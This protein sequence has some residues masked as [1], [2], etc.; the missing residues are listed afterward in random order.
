MKMM[1]DENT[2]SA[3]DRHRYCVIRRARATP[4]MFG[5]PGLLLRSVLA[6]RRI[7]ELIG[8]AGKSSAK[9]G[10]RKFI[11]MHRH[12][13]PCALHH[14]LHEKSADHES[15]VARRKNPQRE[16]KGFHRLRPR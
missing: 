11:Q 5:Q 4:E 16:S 8:E 1:R 13:P 3:T 2:A 10:G 12:D 6:A 7:P 9:S 15:A 14:E